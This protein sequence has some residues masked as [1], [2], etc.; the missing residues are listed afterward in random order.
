MNSYLSSAFTTEDYVNFPTQDCIVDKK[1]ANIDC[2]VDEVTCHLLKLKPNKSP[3]PD[4]IAPCILKSCVPELA[5]SLTYMVTNRSLLAFYLMNE[6]TQVSH[7]YTRRVPNPREK[8]TAQFPLLQ[9]L[10]RLVKKK[11]SFFDRMF[12]FWSEI[13]L[14]NNNQFSFLRGRSTATQLLSTFNY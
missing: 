1:L 9:S 2:C 7:L 11:K 10:V 3:G 14:I 12:K 8:T 13:D 5:P 6:N 4:H